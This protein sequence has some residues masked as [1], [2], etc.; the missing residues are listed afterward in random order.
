MSWLC[1]KSTYA[2]VMFYKCICWLT[3]LLRLA[4]CLFCSPHM[5]FTSL[6]ED[7]IRSPVVVAPSVLCCALLVSPQRFP[8]PI[9]RPFPSPCF[10]SAHLDATR[11]DLPGTRHSRRPHSMGRALMVPT[12]PRARHLSKSRWAE[13]RLERCI[14]WVHVGLLSLS[15]QCARSF[16]CPGAMLCRFALCGGW[17]S[18]SGWR[19]IGL[20]NWCLGQ[21]ILPD[22]RS[23]PLDLVLVLLLWLDDYFSYNSFSF[24]YLFPV[25]GS[26]VSWID[27]FPTGYLERYPIFLYAW[28]D[29]RRL[30]TIIV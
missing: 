4:P 28:F 5:L 29:L 8:H 7:W 21:A 2:Y 17:R 22:G 13:C 24:S 3:F 10:R 16:L 1:I 11:S 12:L 19:T 9:P 26:F 23:G 6:P 14:A 15:W 25:S 18:C 20:R 27:I 30:L